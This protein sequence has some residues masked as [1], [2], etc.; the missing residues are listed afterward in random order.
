[1]HPNTPCDWLKRHCTQHGIRFLGI[2]ALRHLNATLLINS[3]TDIQTVA[4]NLGHSQVSTTLNI[5]TYEFAEAQAA[6][7]EAV[8]DALTGRLKKVK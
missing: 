6:A 2:Y 8:A 5:Y 4:A 1:M 7:S 3:G